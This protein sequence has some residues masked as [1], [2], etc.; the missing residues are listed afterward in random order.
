M[1]HTLRWFILIPSV[2]MSF[3]LPACD[4]SDSPQKDEQA[5]TGQSNSDQGQREKPPA[6]DIVRAHAPPAEIKLLDANATYSRDIDAPNNIVRDEIQTKKSVVWRNAVLGIG[7]FE[8]WAAYVSSIDSGGRVELRLSE[9]LV[10]KFW[11]DVPQGGTLFSTLRTLREGQ[12]VYI[13]GR[14]APT[15]IDVMNTSDDALFPTCFEDG[16][17]L[18]GCEIELES[19]EPL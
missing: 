17:G 3:A 1:T 13:S 9:S 11:A 7:D 5:E 19:I 10:L 6:P 2:V 4:N 12:P 14:I 16:F 15:N 18:V 8:R